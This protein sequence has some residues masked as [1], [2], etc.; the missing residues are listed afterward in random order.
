MIDLCGNFITNID[1]PCHWFYSTYDLIFILF[2]DQMHDLGSEYS[3]NSNRF[4][5][6]DWEARGEL[7]EE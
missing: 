2:L 6:F 7:A 4:V 1:Q 5:D 3:C